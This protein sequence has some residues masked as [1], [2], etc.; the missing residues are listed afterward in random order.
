MSRATLLIG[1]LVAALAAPLIVMILSAGVIACASSTPSE[2]AQTPTPTL[3]LSFAP[4]D[5]GCPLAGLPRSFVFRIDPNALDQVV[6][7]APGFVYHLFWW[8]GFRG[9][10]LDD[11]VV[12][13]PN[14][15]VVARNGERVTN[16]EQGLHGYTICSGSGS[17]YVLPEVPR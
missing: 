7:I 3:R 16:P 14:G 8:Q 15:Q 13:D 9:G 1:D 11:P 17:L 2:P 12:R 6:A 4:A 5:S 10:T